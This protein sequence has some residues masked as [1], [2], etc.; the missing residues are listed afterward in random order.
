M[1]LVRR[2]KSCEESVG[3]LR[4]Q[5][6]DRDNDINDLQK[7]LFDERRNV[8]RLQH[9]LEQMGIKLKAAN[10][11]VDALKE[12]LEHK[13]DKVLRDFLYQFFP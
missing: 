13:D 1:D 7:K 4:V 3:R 12:E 10:D 8:T 2:V 9:E 6:A 5:L 11:N